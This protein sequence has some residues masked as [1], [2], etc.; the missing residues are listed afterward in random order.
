MGPLERTRELTN[1][2]HFPC[3]LKYRLVDGLGIFQLAGSVVLDYQAGQTKGDGI[4][5]L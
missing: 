3:H 5:L 4:I 2:F 1:K